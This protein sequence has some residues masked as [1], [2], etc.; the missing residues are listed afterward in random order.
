MR[1][2]D[3]VGASRWCRHAQ[4]I[5]GVNINRGLSLSAEAFLLATKGKARVGCVDRDSILGSAALA[6]A[7]FNAIL[8]EGHLLADA[9]VSLDLEVAEL[10]ALGASLMLGLL[11]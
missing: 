2:L 9:D 5:A 1:A 10:A 7:F 8:T 6:G 4:F 11:A 3:H